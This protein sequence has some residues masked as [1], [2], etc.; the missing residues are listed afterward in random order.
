VI[1]SHGHEHTPARA[2]GK[3]IDQGIGRRENPPPD[4][5]EPLDLDRPGAAGCA[6][7]LPMMW[8]F[9]ICYLL[10]TVL[11]GYLVSRTIRNEEDYFLGGRRLGWPL[12]SFS[13]FA[14]W[15]GAETC[16]GSS[17]AVYERGLSGS[18]ADP[19][20]YATCLL[21]LGL[22]LAGRLWR[23]KYV[24]L[25][26]FYRERYG[27]LVEKAAVWILAPSS[28]M[29][30]AAQ[31]RAFAQV[32]ASTTSIPVDIALVIVA[33]FVIGYTCLGGFLGD[34]I[35]DFLQGIIIF[36]GVT[37]ILV[38]TL[39]NV[40]DVGAILASIEP[41]RLDFIDEGE[42]LL[43]RLDRW[44]IPILGSLVAQETVSR[45]LAARSMSVARK[46]S[47]IAAGIYLLMGSIPV[48]I[49]LLGPH[50]MPGIEEKEQFLILVAQK[51]LPPVA[52]VLFV[53]ALVAAI[54]ATIDSIL[55]AISAMVT[56]NLLAR[57]LRDATQ[58][59]K[60]IVARGVVAIAG[61]I[62][63]VM[64]VYGGGIYELLETASA[65]GTAGILVITLVGLYTG[66]GGGLSA[67]LALV[68]GLVLTPL[69][70]YVFEWQA[71]FLSSVLGAV[72]GFV[73]GKLLASSVPA[74][75]ALERRMTAPRS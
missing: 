22:L 40:D 73:L 72:I 53:G 66:V 58:R 28:L 9:I 69:G 33:A 23:G 74:L 62:A 55:L 75:A 31:V 1:G 70:K 60:V 48:L 56:H 24:T 49:G 67:A 61:V 32:L 63:Y 15:F 25:A 26:D 43:Q 50:I 41:G 2:P 3:R 44:M 57:A 10:A 38:F 6:E 8:L 36:L 47:F 11:I 4:M 35:T 18:R 54:L 21:L 51:Y 14:T 71:P 37:G 19:F 5:I 20:G 7:R 64:A 46:A 65:F 27:W 45:V 34:V 13:L 12:V 39:R 59:N 68:A 29:W 52:F 30:A 17:A 16:I 42:T